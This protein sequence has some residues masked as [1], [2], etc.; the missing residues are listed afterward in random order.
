MRY[1]HSAT[2]AGRKADVDNVDDIEDLCR[3]CS[4]IDDF[5]LA[6]HAVTQYPM[7]KERKKPREEDTAVCV[8]EW[9]STVD[10]GAERRVLLVKRPEKG[11]SS[12][13]E[14]WCAVLALR[15]RCC[16]GCRSARGLV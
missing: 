1:A 8:V 4:P 6:T 10:T 5:S 15:L 12:P 14:A 13:S 11:Q 16:I 9:Q 7:T 2:S 3:L